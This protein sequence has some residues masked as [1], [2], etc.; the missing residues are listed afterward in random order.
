MLARVQNG[1]HGEGTC[2][3]PTAGLLSGV[4]SARQ[5][6]GTGRPCDQ[7]M[8]T[9]CSR[10]QTGEGRGV[11]EGGGRSGRGGGGVGEGE[12]E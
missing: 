6:L 9:A 7:Q 12:R 8:I 1:C 10:V 4:S 11:G 2:L 5:W 3:Q